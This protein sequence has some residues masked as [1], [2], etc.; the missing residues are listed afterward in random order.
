MGGVRQTPTSLSFPEA[1]CP[2]SRKADATLAKSGG[3]AVLEILSAVE[4][5]FLVEVIVDRAMHGGE[6]RMRRKRSIARSRR[7]NG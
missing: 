6:L 2:M 5:A 7:H 4:V 1:P 3:A